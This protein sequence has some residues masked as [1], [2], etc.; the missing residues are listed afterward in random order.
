MIDIVLDD[1]GRTGAN[2]LLIHQD[3][4]N[5]IFE[6]F[7]LGFAKDVNNFAFEGYPQFQL[8]KDELGGLTAT[9]AR[10]TE[11]FDDRESRHTLIN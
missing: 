1:L 4:W 6:L 11:K 3:H 10:F 9:T 8:L 2:D 5:L 7:V